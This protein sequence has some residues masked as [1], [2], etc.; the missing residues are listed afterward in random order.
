MGDEVIGL[1]TPGFAGPQHARLAVQ[2]AQELLRS[3]GH[4]GDD[5]PWLPVGVGVHTGVAYVGA[6]G[7]EGAVSDVTV[8]GDAANTAARLASAA[9]PGEVLVSEAACAA[10]GIAVKGLER[11]QL[12]LKGRD[13]QV[14]VRVL[15]VR[16]S[17]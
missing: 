6:V 13:E 10:A 14:E 8:L 11:R 16:A 15:R 5:G 3:T 12:R 9:G 4:A 1:Y 2:A 17:A 7:S